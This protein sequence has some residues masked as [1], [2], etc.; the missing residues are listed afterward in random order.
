[1]LTC[2]YCL[3]VYPELTSELAKHGCS[4]CGAG[5]LVEPK[6]LGFLPNPSYMTLSGSSIGPIGRA[7]YSGEQKYYELGRTGFPIR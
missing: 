3:R 5:F 2:M 7:Y 6:A 4:G 1:M